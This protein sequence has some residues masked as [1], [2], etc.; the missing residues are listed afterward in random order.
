MNEQIKAASINTINILLFTKSPLMY[1]NI[2]N[3]LNCI[4]AM[5]SE[6]SLNV[7]WRIVQGVSLLMDMSMEKIL[8]NF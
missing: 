5:S 3:Y 1:E 6:P 7:R 4:L 2:E 8:Q